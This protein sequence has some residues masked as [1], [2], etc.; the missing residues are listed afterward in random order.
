MTSV[1]PG[2]LRTTWS[3]KAALE[4]GSNYATYS[5]IIINENL[6]ERIIIYCAT[7][8]SCEYLYNKLQ[9]Y[10]PNLL[11][12]YFHG[13]LQDNEKEKAMKSWKSNH[14]LIIIATSAFGMGINS[15]N[16]R[17]VIHV[18]APM[19]SLIQ[20][21]GRTGRDGNMAKHFIFYSKKDIYTNYSIVAE[22]R[23][24]T[25][26][27][28]QRLI[29]KLERAAM[30]IFESNEQKPPPKLLDGKE[31]IIKLLKVIEYL[32]QETG[33]QIGPDDVIDVFRGGKTAK[34]KQKNW[35][36]LPIYPTEKRKVLKTKDLVQFALTDLVV[37]SLV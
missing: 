13:S 14:T 11:I 15:N 29:N 22:H 36:T 31:E 34:I 1:R 19:T 20:E 5:N 6:P 3:I 28:E 27:E 17:V 23:E 24:T 4:T 2:S 9:E 8:S 12:D 18:E 33:E 30:K 7:H 35:N 37:R 32:T 16:I 21:A 26:V 10:L 25:N